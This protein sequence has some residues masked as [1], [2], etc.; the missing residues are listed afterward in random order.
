MHSGGNFRV[1]P[2]R[3]Y[4]YRR[5]RASTSHRL[6]EKA[7]RALQAANLRFLG[8]I[9]DRDRALATTIRARG[10]S[11]ET[12]LA[13][14]ELLRALKDRKMWQA[15]GIVATRPR[16]AALLRLPIGVRLRRVLAWRLGGERRRGAIHES[17][18]LG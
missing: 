5:H 2:L 3:L 14:E 6:G 10:R 15:L 17:S 9:A 12:A 4:Y 13:Y 8:Q 1:Y 11:I 7:L 16:A 18:R